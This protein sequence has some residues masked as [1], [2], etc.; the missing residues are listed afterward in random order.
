VNRAT[1]V[2]ALGR[3]V[4]AALI[5]LLAVPSTSC[6]VNDYCL[7][8]A[9]TDS[10]GDPDAAPTFDGMPDADPSSPD[11]CVVGSVEICD[12]ADNDCDGDIDEDVDN[13]GQQCGDA[14][15]PCSL[16]TWS[17]VAGELVCSGDLPSPEQ[18]DNVDN[19]CDT[20]VDEG[21]P[22]GGARCGT[23]VGECISGAERCVDGA[24]ECVG[25]VG[26]VG[27]APELCDGRDNDC[28]GDFDEDLASPGACTTG[29]DVGLCELGVQQ[30]RGGVYVCEGA[31]GPTFELCD[32]AGEDQD[33]DG[34]PNNGYDLD[35]DTRNCGTC[36][37][38]CVVPNASPACVA[39]GCVVGAC[40]AGF[41]NVDGD[42]EPGDTFGCEYA[43][44]F[45]GAF[46]ACNLADDD[47]DGNVDEGVTPPPGFCASV[48]ACATM[49]TTTCTADGF[50]CVYGNPEASVDAE[51]NLEP[52]IACDD[53]DNDCDGFV[54]ESHPLKGTAC[55]DGEDGICESFGEYICDPAD[56][57]GGVIC[58]ITTPG[59]VATTES[60]NGL[61]DDCDGAID[62]GFENG[63]LAEWV[64]LTSGVQ[65]MKYEASRPDATASEVGSQ[66]G[67]AC[68][69]AG[70]Q[71]WTNVK[72]PEAEAVCTAMG[73]RLC[74]EAEWEASCLA[75]T[76]ETFTYPA[77][78]VAGP[79][80]PTDKVIIQAENNFAM[81]A[82]TPVGGGCVSHSWLTQNPLRTGYSGASAL[83]ALPNT[84]CNV[85]TSTN[86]PTQATRIDFKFNLTAGTYYVWVRMYAESNSD[87]TVWVALGN[88]APLAPSTTAL[89]ASNGSWQWLVSQSFTV[90]AGTRFASVYMRENGVA[91]DAIA[92]SKDNQVA[93]NLDSAWATATSPYLAQP[94]TCNTDN[95]DTDGGTPGDQDG[96]LTTGSLANCYANGTGA[97]DAYDFTGNVKEWTAERS[98]GVNPQ[99]GGAASNELTG[100]TCALDFTLAD[101]DFFFPNVGFRCC[102]NTP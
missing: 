70:V 18:C 57:L 21:D 25:A 2:P 11:A 43:C 93:P 95:Y 92:I 19:D 76:R 35:T 86:A 68:S 84:G 63:S 20:N 60:C 65:V 45:A 27:G 75:S 15:P 22:G 44:D 83:A 39:G 40:N 30:C 26:E 32:L 61:D 88:S 23:D 42:N 6:D 51:G 1:V 3:G 69:K 52:E 78:G 38:V 58:D 12:N 49:T 62:N 66:G 28:D 80:G 24:L 79:T 101:D 37:N 91:V 4:A 100:S 82:A 77:A 41:Y 96:V 50:D 102:R 29:T 64:E 7:N 94:T 90:T 13:V 56:E 71:P 81:T 48:G 8:C 17:C 31:V 67:H 55:G 9:N 53:I 10:S 46:E 34:D 99:R 5:G 89:D 33:C 54:D 14:D 16:G 97:A 74:S 98:A 87:D 47:C 72:Q 85:T 59:E 73:A 36:G